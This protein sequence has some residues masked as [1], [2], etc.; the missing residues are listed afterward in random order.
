MPAYLVVQINITDPDRFAQYRTAV[1][2]VVES[3]GGRYLTRGA[4]VEV[5]STRLEC[6]LIDMDGEPNA[7]ETPFSLNDVGGNAC[8]CGSDVLPCKVLSAG[9]APPTAPSFD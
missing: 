4:Q 9:L 7:L 2:G 1:P 8:G 6:N 3:F 5:A